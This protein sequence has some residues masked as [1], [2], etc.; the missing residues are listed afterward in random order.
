MEIFFNEL[1][2]QPLAADSE[3]ATLK[4]ITLLETLKQLR[5]DSFNIMRTSE[6]FYS[7]ELATGYSVAQFFN[8]P[9]ISRDLKTLLKGVAKKPYLEDETLYEAE[10][11]ILSDFK[12]KNEVGVDISPEG[13]ATAYVFNSPVISLTGHSH[14]QRDFIPITITPND[15]KENPIVANITNVYSVESI[16]GKPFRDW[17]Q[18][19]TEGIQLN[20]EAN[21]ALIF[22]PDKFEFDTRAVKELISWYHD[23]KRFIIRIKELINDIIT[24]PFIGGKGLTEIL[25]GSG[26]KASKRIIKKDRIVYTYTK[27]KITI[28]Q[29]R[30]HYDDN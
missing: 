3:T 29:C 6:Y 14:W 27:E 9:T 28:H 1:S 11:F 22:S 25:G 13:L 15:D 20:S 2:C 17:L 26:G 12:T 30:G 7:L 24:N 21:I 19:L 8:D 10:I 5:K 16:S 18:S 23:D 4:I